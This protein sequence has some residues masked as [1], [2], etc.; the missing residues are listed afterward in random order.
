MDSKPEM[1]KLNQGLGSGEKGKKL[2]TILSPRTFVNLLN[3]GLGPSNINKRNKQELTHFLP[4][5]V[6]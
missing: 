6:P 3:F 1:K 5:E 2:C 4:K